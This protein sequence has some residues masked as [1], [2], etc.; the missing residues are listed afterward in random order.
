MVIV[1]SILSLAKL[2]LSL[3]LAISFFLFHNTQYVWSAVPR[4]ILEVKKQTQIIKPKRKRT[5]QLILEVMKN[6]MKL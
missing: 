3:S 6:Q 4:S 2:G 5:A 1:F